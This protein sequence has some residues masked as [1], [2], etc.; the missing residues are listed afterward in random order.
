IQNLYNFI[1]KIYVITCII[2]N[3]VDAHVGQHL[4]QKVIGPNG[5][6]SKKTRILA[7]HNVT[8]LKQVDKI[9]VIENGEI[10]AQGTYSELRSNNSLSDMIIGNSETKSDQ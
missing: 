7:T 6:L 4:F 5:I 1:Y 10:I 9:V 2:Y 8:F 3:L